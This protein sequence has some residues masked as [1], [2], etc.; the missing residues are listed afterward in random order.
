[1]AELI[2]TVTEARPIHNSILVGIDHRFNDG[3]YD[4]EVRIIALTFG[5]S[6]KT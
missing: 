3:A 5:L 4:R 6:E 1:M 2:S